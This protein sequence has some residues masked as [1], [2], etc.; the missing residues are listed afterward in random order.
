MAMHAER[1]VAET[2]TS[3]GAAV[4]QAGLAKRQ[5]AAKGQPWVIEPASGGRPGIE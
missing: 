1:W 5:R 2:E 3:S 4:V